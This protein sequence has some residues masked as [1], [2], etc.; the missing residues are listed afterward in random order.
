M[1]PIQDQIRELLAGHRIVLFMKGTRLAPECGFSSSVVD[2]LDDLVDEYETVNVLASPSM[3]DGI[4]AFSDWPTIPQLYV[5]G[6]FVGGADIVKEMA[7]QGELAG[8]LGGA[9]APAV[10]PTIALSERAASTIKEMLKDAAPDEGF[11]RLEVSA[12]FHYGLFLGGRERGDVEVSSNGVTILLD[13]VSARRADGMR[14]DYVESAAGAGFKIE[15][16]NEPPKVRSLRV[17]EMR[18]MQE[19]GEEFEL[20]DVR[21]EEERNTAAIAGSHLLD[22]V[23]KEFVRRL[24]IDAK[25]VFYCH[26]GMRSR[27]AAEHFLREGYTNVWNLEGGIDAWSLRVDP[28]VPRY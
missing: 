21:T 6:K 14:I 18:A 10:I 4:K 7:A 27:A 9:T 22:E 12:Q 13:R 2:I 23:G 20:L 26:H 8:M 1:E 16:P 17:E 11:L 5:D 28:S 25:L 15:N 19:A 3:R 24:P